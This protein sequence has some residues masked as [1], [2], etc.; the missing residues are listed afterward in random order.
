MG[1]QITPSILN[2][3]L[4]NLVNEIQ[5]IP[6]ADW[7]HID[8]MDGHFVPNL[9]I[10]LPVVESLA[11]SIALPMDCHLMIED[12][13][14]WAP[15]YIEA[16]AKSA[17]FHIEAAKNPLQIAKDVKSAGGRAGMAF[18]PGTSL[19]PYLD[20]IPA[21][22]MILIMT[23]EPGFGG[24][25]FMDECVVKIEQAR[26]EINRYGGSIWLQVDGGLS[27]QTIDRC[28]KAGADV[29]VAGSAIYSAPDPEQMVEAL[30]SSAITAFR[31]NN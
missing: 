1:I 30:R 10:G 3:D 7:V 27:L 12:P 5:R 23:V 14:R 21:M 17:T 19:I 11:K 16:G 8:V 2:A 31:A 6:S 26:K 9:T 25:K 4:G 29:F 22:D 20:L 18:K 24:Q 13:D 15:T 28:A